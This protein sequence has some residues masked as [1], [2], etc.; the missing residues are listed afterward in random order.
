MGLMVF[1]R[2]PG[3]LLFFLLNNIM[4]LIAPDFTIKMLKK[5]LSTTGKWGF[6]EKI[7][8]VEDVEYLFSFA[9]VKKQLL[10]GLENAIKDAQRGSLAPNP[11][12]YDLTSRSTVSLLTASRPARPLVLNFGSCS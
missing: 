10:H 6:D 5:Q 9:C 11:A 4:R 7:N 2:F 12:V 8:S 1:I 3:I